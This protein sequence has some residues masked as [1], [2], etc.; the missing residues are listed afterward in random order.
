MPDEPKGLKFYLCQTSVGPQYVHLQADAKKTDP[1]YETV[2]VDTSK[3]ALMDRLNHLIRGPLQGI[4]LAEGDE[5]PDEPYTAPTPAPAPQTNLRSPHVQERLQRIYDATGFED[6]IWNIPDEEAF[7][8][9]N[10]ENIIKE[11]RD[12]I[13]GIKRERA[14][15]PEPTKSRWGKK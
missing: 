8:L 9:D 11:R 6:F 4:S 7:R 1:N 15:I 2:Y 5:D 14:P 10:L 13:N 3:Q 12:E